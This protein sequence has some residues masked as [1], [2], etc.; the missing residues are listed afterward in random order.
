MASMLRFVAA[1]S[2]IVL[3]AMS[4]LARRRAVF[5]AVLVAFV[6]GDWFFTVG[7]LEEWLALV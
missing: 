7:W 2:P 4:L 6:V 5:A 3:L 1:L